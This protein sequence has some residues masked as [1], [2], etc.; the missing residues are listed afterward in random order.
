MKHTYPLRAVARLLEYPDENLLSYMSDVQHALDQLPGLSSSVKKG[1]TQFC[2]HLTHTDLLQLQEE[3]VECFDRG[4]ST[5]LHLFEHVHGDSRERGQAMIDL[6]E[7]YKQA[8]FVLAEK[9]ELPDHLP[10]ALEFASVI[11][12][13]QAAD[14]LGEMAHILN[15]IHTAL[16]NRGSRYAWLLAAVI[17]FSGEKIKLTHLQLDEKSMDEEWEEPAAFGGCSTVGQSKP[18]AEQPIQFMKR[19]KS[20]NGVRI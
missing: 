9:K 15:S 4:R 5:S 11:D 7:T 1:L 2:Q 16:V 6:M 18:G 12:Q 14:F 13:R 3:Y 8:H 20:A 19:E 17:E 10:V